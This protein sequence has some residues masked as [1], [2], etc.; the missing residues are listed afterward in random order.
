MIFQSGRMRTSQFRGFTLIELLVVIAIIAILAAILFPVFAKA[1]E[2][3]RQTQCT[4]NQKQIVTA[5]M[6]WSQE[7]DEK[8]PQANTFWTDINVPPKVTKCYNSTAAIAYVYDSDLS[9]RSLAEIEDATAVFMTVDGSRPTYTAAAPPAPE[10]F[11]N[12]F[13]VAEDADS[14][15]HAN[16][17]V[18]AYV[19]GHVELKDIGAEPLRLPFSTGDGLTAVYYSEVNFTGTTATRVDQKVD[20]DFTGNPSVMPTGIDNTNLSVRWTG[21]V[22]AKVTGKYTFY[23]GSDDGSKLWLTNVADADTPNVNN[24]RDQGET[25][26]AGTEISLNAGQKV[27]LRMD[28]YQGGGG[29]QARLRWSINNNDG[30]SNTAKE[31]IPKDYLFSM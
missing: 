25:E 30:S 14:V 27:K 8:F 26:V 16:K 21:Y 10:M 11:A 3:A 1:R 31:I 6:L 29:G 18:V 2:K 24:W 22:K 13:Y 7:N 12:C 9:G 17:A 23:T 4:S 28:Y 19:D 15:R 20:F 5:A